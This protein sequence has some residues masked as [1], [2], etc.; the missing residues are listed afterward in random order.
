MKKD[1]L[2]ELMVLAIIIAYTISAVAVPSVIALATCCAI[3][4]YFPAIFSE[5]G[6]CS[7]FVVIFVSTLGM[8]VFLSRAIIVSRPATAPAET[9][10][11]AIF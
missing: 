8:F 3:D 10:A 1:F 7:M 5:L 11:N 6:F 9:A 2:D 4:H